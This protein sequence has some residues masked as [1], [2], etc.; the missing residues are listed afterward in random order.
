MT[1]LKSASFNEISELLDFT[2]LVENLMQSYSH[3]EDYFPEELKNEL[4]KLQSEAL[5]TYERLT[6]ED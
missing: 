3:V 6:E 5:S 4:K 1:N 2:A